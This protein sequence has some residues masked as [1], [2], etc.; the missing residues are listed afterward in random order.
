MGAVYHEFATTIG[1]RDTF[2]LVGYPHWVDSRLISIVAGY[3]TATAHHAPNLAIRSAARQ[4]VPGALHR[5]R[6]AKTL[7]QLYPGA[8]R[9]SSKY[10][11]KNFFMFFVPPSQ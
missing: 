10:E 5:C 3:R 4:A 2:W 6:F 11:T 8:S 1:T 7:K 9:I